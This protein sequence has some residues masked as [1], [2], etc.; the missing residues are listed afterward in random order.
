MSRWI[1]PEE[2]AE[3]AALLTSYTRSAY[4]LEGQQVYSDPDE[5]AALARFLDGQPPAIDLSRTISRTHAQVAAGRTKTRVRVIIE[6]PTDYTR[7]ELVIYPELAAAGEDI[8]IIA[9]PEGDWPA[10]LPTYDYWL[11]D[12][13]EVWRMHYNDDHTARGAE[14]LEGEDVLADHLQWRDNALRQAVPLQGYLAVGAS[15]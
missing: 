15:D 1:G 10:G 5:D 11:F 6:P 3:W 7:L 12:D 9:V 14:L 4:R 2:G 8:L 13:R